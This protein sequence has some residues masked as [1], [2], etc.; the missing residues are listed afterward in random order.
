MIDTAA[1]YQNEA[2]VGDGVR[3]GGVDRADIFL[4]TKLWISDYG[5]DSALHGFERSTRKLGFDTL[6]LYLLHQPMP[7]EFDRTVAAWRAAERLLS[8]GRIR[9]IGVCNFSPAHLDR[10]MAETDVTPAVNQVEAHPFFTQ[11]DLI[12]AHQRLGVATQAWSPIGGVQRY[13]GDDKKPE[14][15]PLTHPVVTALAEKHAKTPAQIVLRWHIDLGVSV[16]P[17]SV[18]AKRIVENLDVFDFRLTADEIASIDTLD[19]GNRGGPD[20]EAINT[21]TITRKIED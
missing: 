8:E 6:D 16:I 9:A 17:K 10:L 12:A 20:P 13:W 14:D 2:Q 7:T 18:H 11:K 21:R 1:A 4:Q 3:A 5:F 15:D 19:T